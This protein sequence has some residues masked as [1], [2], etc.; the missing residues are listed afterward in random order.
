MTT[1]KKYFSTVQFKTL[2]G[3][4]IGFVIL[5]GGLI[6]WNGFRNEPAPEYYVEYLVSIMSLCV[7]ISSFFVIKY[8]EAPRPG[9]T[10]IKGT[11]AVIQGI[12]ALLISG[13]V[14]IVLFYDATVSLLK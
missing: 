3:F 6:K 13:S 10:S 4:V 7:A 1:L 12:I 9:L 8:K 5:F 14:F 11:W 2:G